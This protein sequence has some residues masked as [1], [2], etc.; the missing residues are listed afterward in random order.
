MLQ[1]IEQIPNNIQSKIKTIQ[2]NWDDEKIPEILVNSSLSEE[3]N[4]WDNI[5]CSDLLYDSK[6]HTS[7]LRL[8]SNLHFNRLILSYKRRHD[9]EEKKFFQLLNDKYSIKLVKSDTIDLKNLNKVSLSG[10]HLLIIT[11]KN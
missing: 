11:P 7:L 3:N 9:N 1:N 2:F 8:I 4:V 5:I 10:L 6:Y